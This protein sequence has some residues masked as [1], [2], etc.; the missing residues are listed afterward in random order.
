MP[1]VCVGQ[2]HPLCTASPD[3]LWAVKLKFYY[4]NHL[5]DLCLHLFENKR[6]WSIFLG[7]QNYKYTAARAHMSHALCQKTCSSCMCSAQG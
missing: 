5:K 2:F 6:P 7:T 1:T 4:D 3:Q